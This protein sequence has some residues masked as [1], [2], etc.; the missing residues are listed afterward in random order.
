MADISNSPTDSTLLGF[1]GQRLSKENSI[2]VEWAPSS[3]PS[4]PVLQEPPTPALIEEDS[5][6]K[7]QQQQKSGF[8]LY[9]MFSHTSPT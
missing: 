6:L 1:N 7:P 8:K 5:V 9:R 3:A 4:A 2:K